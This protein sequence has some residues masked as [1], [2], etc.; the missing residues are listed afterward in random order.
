MIN[1]KLYNQIIQISRLGDSGKDFLKK[2]VQQ[3]I[4]I[5]L[6]ENIFFKLH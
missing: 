3:I 2:N 4:K 6:Y 1:D 5:W